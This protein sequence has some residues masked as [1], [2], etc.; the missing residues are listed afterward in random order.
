MNAPGARLEVVAGNASGMSI[1]VEDELFIGR[2]TDGA[3]RLAEDDEIS[4]QH[5]RVTLDHSGVCAIEDLGST[6]GTFVNGLRI[7]APKTL[8]EGDTIELGGTTLVVREI[9]PVSERAAAPPPGDTPGPPPLKPTAVLGAGPE[10]PTVKHEPPP[11]SL[12]LEIDFGAL[13]ARLSLGA[14]AEPPRLVF[15]SGA[16]RLASSLPTEKGTIDEL[17][18]GDA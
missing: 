6:N 3:G 15:D 13:E 9:P 14:G 5:A 4:R 7:T 18:P 10:I 8:C 17:R 1:V 16:W 12:Q 11:L 2:E